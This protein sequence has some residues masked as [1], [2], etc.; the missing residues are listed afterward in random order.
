MRQC[1]NT[2]QTILKHELVVL[3]S[4]AHVNTPFTGFHL[5]II[6]REGVTR[7]RGF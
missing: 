4:A 2:L 1:T 5:E 6:V 3:Q 7:L